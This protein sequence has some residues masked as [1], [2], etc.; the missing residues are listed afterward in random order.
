M[1]DFDPEDWHTWPI[2]GHAVLTRWD[3]AR[4]RRLDQYGEGFID[5]FEKAL[6]MVHEWAKTGEWDV[7]A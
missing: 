1:D 7:N 2:P 5:G 3:D 6:H 4:P